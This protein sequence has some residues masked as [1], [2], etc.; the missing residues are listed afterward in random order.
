VSLSDLSQRVPPPPRPV[1][2]GSPPEWQA[3]EA[4]LGL[5]LPDDYK[6]MVGTYGLGRFADFLTIFTPFAKNEYVNL[7]AQP[8]LSLEAYRAL[9]AD[10]PQIAPFPAYPEPG[11]LLSWAQSDNGDVVY[12]LTE[13]NA[14]TW[15]I[16]LIES[17]HGM[18]ERYDVPTTDFLAQVI[19]GS[20]PTRILPRDLNEDATFTS[21]ET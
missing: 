15:P 1:G 2:T 12:W 7:L 17:R 11:G 10:H 21:L 4:K 8:E 14:A 5:E 6:Q 19:E 16:V 9:R 3:V 13:G 18:I 20:L